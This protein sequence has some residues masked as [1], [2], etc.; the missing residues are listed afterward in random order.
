MSIITTRG[1]CL[2]PGHIDLGLFVHLMWAV[3][4]R[5]VT[6]S[7][8]LS[9]W[10][11]KERTS[12]H[13][14][15]LSSHPGVERVY[16]GRT[17]TVLQSP[18]QH[19]QRRNSGIFAV[20]SRRSGLDNRLLKDSLTDTRDCTYDLL[21]LRFTEHLQCREEMELLSMK[22]NTEG[23]MWCVM[24]HCKNSQSFPIMGHCKNSQSFPIVGHCKNSQSFPIMGHCK[25]SQSFPIMGYYK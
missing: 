15:E 4:W 19:H 2:W 14:T 1:V 12:E 24:G 20:L 25:N 22:R 16:K 3:T 18:S 8:S 21:H 6:K 11:K 13:H 7:N 10:G 23:S 5:A 9:A 17:Q